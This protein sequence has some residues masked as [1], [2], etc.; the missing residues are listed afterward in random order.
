MQQT[1]TIQGT[2]ERAKFEGLGVS[3][4]FI[5]QACLDGKLKHCRAGRKILIFYPN[6]LEL[7]QTGDFLAEPL[8][9]VNTIHKL[10]EKYSI[11][12]LA[13]EDVK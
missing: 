6:L 1:N 3:R 4:N 7:L 13:Q 11:N 5:R 8:T 12:N 10:P 9:N 2:F